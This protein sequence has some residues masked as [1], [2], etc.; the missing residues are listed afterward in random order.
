MPQP[1]IKGI[2]RPPMAMPAELQERGGAVKRRSEVP[3]LIQLY[4]WFCFIRA[5]TYVTFAFIE[6]GA[7]DSTA[8]AFLTA[9]F[10]FAPKQASPE[11]VF[12]VLAGL[13][14]LIGWRWLTRDWRARWAAM[15]IHGAVGVRVLIALFADRAAGEPTFSQGQ[16]Q[17]MI[18]GSIFN[19]GICA[20]LAFY[21][22]MDQTF[23]ETPWD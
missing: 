21:P 8:A 20:Y 2:V 1:E 3:L 17:A 10:D 18:L 14:A 16:T 15:F 5:V 11:I 4:T 23:K 19:L 13:Y 22:G 12:F 7:P 9:H 6:G